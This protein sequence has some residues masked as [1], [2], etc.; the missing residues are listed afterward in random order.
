[1]LVC[2]GTEAEG[3]KQKAT[4]GEGLV[5]SLAR[6]PRMGLPRNGFIETSSPS[7]WLGLGPNLGRHWCGPRLAYGPG[8]GGTFETNC[9]THWYDLPPFEVWKESSTSFQIFPRTPE[10]PRWPKLPQAERRPPAWV[11]RLSMNKGQL[12]VLQRSGSLP[13]KLAGSP[14]RSPSTKPKLVLSCGGAYYWPPPQDAAGTKSPSRRPKSA[15]SSSAENSP[16]RRLPESPTGVMADLES[17]ND[18]RAAQ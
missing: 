16:K 6:V 18:N 2:G 12:A 8:P 15:F 5:R 1:M 13:G 14:T 10:H 17:A 9:P 7:A 3:A 11:D 4:V